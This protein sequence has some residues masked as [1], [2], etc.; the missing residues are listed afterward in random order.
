MGFAESPLSNVRITKR[1]ERDLENLLKKDP[2]NFKRVWEDLR[3]YA[4]GK[5]PQSPKP[6]KGF[7]PPLWQVESGDFRLFHTWDGSILW[8]RGV[9]KKPEQSK[10]FKALR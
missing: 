7:K 5:L 8:L 2:V 9:L 10:R 6:L 4:L 3:R 1:A